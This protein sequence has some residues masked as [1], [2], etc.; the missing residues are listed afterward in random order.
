MPAYPRDQFDDVPRDAH[1]IGAHRAAPR[2]GRIWIVI[3]V[4]ALAAVVLTVVGILG[5][6]RFGYSGI[7]LSGLGG[8][9]GGDSAPAVDE[10]EPVTDPTLLEPGVT[11]AVL[12]GTDAEGL[13]A[14]VGDRLQQAGWPVEASGNTS[15]ANV[16]TTTVYY[17]DAAQEGAALGIAQLLGVDQVTQS[18]AFPTALTVV[19]GAD[20][21]PDAGE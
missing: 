7:D 21:V 18:D 4:W 9:D 16:E 19:L 15:A 1:R 20:Q 3:G 13:A 5:L 10:V 11:I 6:S 12:N 8:A 2:R 14:Q 17:A